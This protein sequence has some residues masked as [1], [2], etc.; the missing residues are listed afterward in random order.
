MPHFVR[1]APASTTARFIFRIFGSRMQ[2]RMLRMLDRGRVSQMLLP[3]EAQQN[4][5]FLY[6]RTAE[7]HALQV[8]QEELL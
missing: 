1:L 4:R 8:A 7:L 3:L 6:M 5:M 2:V